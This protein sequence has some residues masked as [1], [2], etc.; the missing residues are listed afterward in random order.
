MSR[1][2]DRPNPPLPRRALLAASLLG[3]GG[4]L[5]AL[6]A[7]S[8]PARA[9]SRIVWNDNGRAILVARSM[10][11][12]NPMP[13][14]LY[15]LPKG[16]ARDGMT[17][18]STLR[19]TS[20]HGSLVAVST[21]EPASGA[22][23]GMNEAGLTGS[24]LWLSES[25][26]GKY[27]PTAR[28]LSVGQWLQYYLDEFATVEDAVRATQAAPFQVVTGRFDGRAVAVHL[29]LT[30]ATGDTAVFEYL[31]ARLTIHHGRQYTV[32]T[33]S[34]PYD[35]QL[36]Q[37]RQYKGFGGDK[38]LPGTSDA[39]DRFVRGAYYVSNLPKP[40][41]YREAVAAM[42]SVIRNVS[43]P[44]GEADP[45]RPYVSVTRWRT[46]A[47]VT[48]RIYYFESSTSPNLVWVRLAALDFA[49]ESGVRRLD[50][51]G[52]PDRVGDVT[53][54]FLPAKPFTVAPPDLT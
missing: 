40:L 29:A 52:H 4:S 36:A 26:Y 19:W 48:N 25:D 13:T 7:A 30:D 49:Q 32:M 33:N 41:D 16:M 3:G 50:L 28:S 14:D 22:S 45:A 9:C 53:D 27:D 2:I 21:R 43:A 24:L 38:P 39:A 23:D 8:S 44:F 12:V 1:Q 15:A 51:V 54:Q 46:V 35:Q 10:D 47:D 42:L 18:P 31:G 34:P 6:A 11:W 20:R 37:L 17:G 5:A